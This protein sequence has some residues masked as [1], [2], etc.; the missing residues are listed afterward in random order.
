MA[1]ICSL[2]HSCVGEPDFCAASQA[3][4]GVCIQSVVVA[5]ETVNNPAAYTGAPA[6]VHAPIKAFKVFILLFIS[7]LHLM[8]DNRPG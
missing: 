6:S 2:H 4:T 1:I 7:L 8:E 3:D 5:M